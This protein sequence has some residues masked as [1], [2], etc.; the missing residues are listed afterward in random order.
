[1]SPEAAYLNFTIYDGLN[2][3]NGL[4]VQYYSNNNFLGKPLYRTRISSSFIGSDE[5]NSNWFLFHKEMRDFS[6]KMTTLFYL[7]EGSGRTLTFYSG[8]SSRF[9][10]FVNG[11]LAIKE[12]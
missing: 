3:K 10:L 4:L 2:F 11:E 8:F 5:T 9:T 7:P 1:M 6:V 12:G